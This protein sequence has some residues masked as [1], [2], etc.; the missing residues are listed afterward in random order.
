MDTKFPEFAGVAVQDTLEIRRTPRLGDALD[1]LR[2]RLLQHGERHPQLPQ[3]AL[4]A[5]TS[6]TGW[7]RLQLRLS[8]VPWLLLLLLGTWAATRELADHRTALLA[9]W[10]VGTLPVVVHMSRKWFPHLHAAAWAPIALWLVLRLRDPARRGR[11]GPWLALGAVQGLRLHTHPI[12]APDVAILYGLL[13]VALATRA[14]RA[15]LGRFGAALA[16]TAVL[17]APALFAG[18]LHSDGVGLA[19]YVGLVGQY[20]GADWMATPAGW[21]DVAGRLGAAAW[22]A[23]LPGALL[24]LLWGLGRAPAVL[25]RDPWTR[26]IA[27]RVALHVPAVVLTVGNGGFLSDWLLLAPDLAILAA[28]G[29]RSVRAAAPIAFAQGAIT[30]A[31]PLALSLGPQLQ[32]EGI[33]ALFAR[34]E[35]GGSWNTHHIPVR[36][37]GA[38]ARVAAALPSETGQITLIDLTVRAGGCGDPGGAWAWEPADPGFSA[39]PGQ[40]AFAEA[41]GRTPDWVTGPMS[42]GPAVVRVWAADLLEGACMVAPGDRASLLREAVE[43]TRRALGR[44]TVA[45]DDPAQLIVSAPRPTTEP[46]PGYVGALLVP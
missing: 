40:D 36:I 13:A 3:A 30:V 38:T 4:V 17:G 31:L 8:N 34:S 15:W 20:L 43:P 28:L 10:I 46:V 7:S 35:H 18:A 19:S 22:W 16:T 32:A 11:W 25:R 6:V 5:W 23:L 12:G 14:D 21:S 39:L 24:V 9:V 41:W 27:L 44:P 42:G 29:L 37:D 2:R 45:L 26:L 33:A 1:I